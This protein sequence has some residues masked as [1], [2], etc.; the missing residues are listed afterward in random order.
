[1]PK[2]PRRT[3]TAALVDE[4]RELLTNFSQ[5]L[6]DDD[7]RARVRRLVPAFDTLRNI[8]AS[9][10]PMQGSE[11]AMRRILQYFL[12]YP[13]V[14]IAGK[15]LLVVSGIGEWA[16]RLRQLRTEQGW[17]IVSGS[18]IGD[19]VAEGELD[20]LSFGEHRVRVDD[21]VLLSEDQDRDAAHRWNV[22]NAIRRSSGSVQNRILRYL[23][24]N[25]AQP[26]TGEELMYVA[27]SRTEWAR[28][29]RELRTEEGWAVVTRN[30]GRPDLAIGVYLLEH[31][32]QLETHDRHIPDAV[33]REV[34]RRDAFR[35]T[36]CGWT[37][38]QWRP[39]DARS[40]ELH[41]VLHHVRGGGNTAANL[42]TLCNVC[43]DVRHAQ[44][45][46]RS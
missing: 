18:T 15:E 28:R 2:Q 8:G 11:A 45:R 44:E 34:L 29:V 30:T 10:V 25:V 42:V 35:C 16:R 40:L 17:A 43:H 19:M 14:L 38:D 12:R 7:L 9:L 21:Y 32:R 1:M 6:A 46:P 36:A 4:L 13:R 37:R 22:A 41:H 33:R 5:A 3:D 23:R 27:R 39:E 24:A 31:D 20:E 26:V